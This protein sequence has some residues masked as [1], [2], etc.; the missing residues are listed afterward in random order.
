MFLTHGVSV[1][2]ED[3]HCWSF[4]YATIGKMLQ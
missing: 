2:K 1:L 4:L 3:S